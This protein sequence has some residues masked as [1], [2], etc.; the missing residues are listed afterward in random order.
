MEL[1]KDGSDLY[2]TSIKEVYLMWH[3]GEETPIRSDTVT[4]TSQALIKQ[5]S[6]LQ[7]LN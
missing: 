3:T 7:P 5:F 4:F 1:T 2:G 6:H